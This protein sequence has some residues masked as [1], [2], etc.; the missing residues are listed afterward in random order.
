MQDT[1]DK[2]NINFAHLHVHTEFSLLDGSSKIKEIIDKTKELNMNSLAITDHGVMYG[3]ID[4]YKYALK[5]GIKPI[6]GCEVY[7]AE[8][9]RFDKVKSP[10]NNHHHLVLLAETNE[11]YNNLLKLVSLGHVEGF[12]Y[13]PR[14]DLEILRK[15]H[16]GLICLS[17]CLAG[18]VPRAILR[19]SYEAGKEVALTYKEIFGEDNFFLELQNH[20][21]QDQKLVNQNLIEMSEE[22]NIPLVCTNDVHYT[23]RSDEQSHDILLCIQTKKTVDD[24]NRMRYIGGQYYLKSPV[25]MLDLFGYVPEAL[26]NTQKIANRCNVEIDFNNYKLPVFP[27]PDELNINAFEYIKELCYDGLKDRYKD[28]NNNSELELKINERLDYEINIIKEMGFID[29]FLIVWDFIKY[30]RDN[31]IIVGP[32]R[33]SAAGSLVSYCLGITDIDPIEYNLIFERFLNPERVSMPDIDIDFCY[34]RRQE[35]ID[36]VNKKYGEDRVSQII[37]FGTLAARNAIRSVGRAISMP[38]DKVDKIAKMIPKELKITI[39]DALE[40]NP[41]LSKKYNQEEDVKYLIDMAMRLEGLSRHSSTHAAG[42]VIS[43]RPITDYIPVSRNDNII[44]TQFP[45]TTIEELGLLKMDFLGLR[46]LTVIK[47]AFDEINR[48]HNLNISYKDINYQ[49]SKIYELIASGNTEGIFQLES[50]GMKQMIKELQPHSIEDV[51][52][53]IS[54]YRPGPM[55]FI[56]NYIQGKN[57]KHNIKYDHKLLEPILKTTYGCIVYQEQVMQ[58]AQD[59]AGYNLGQSDLLRRA[60]GKKKTSEMEKERKN[61]IYG[62]EQIAG[63]LSNGISEGVA[64]K[65]FDQMQDFAKYAFNK[66]HAASYAVI[67]CQT[68]WIKAYYPLEFMS[69]L[70]TSVMD[71]IPKIAEYLVELRRIDIKILPPDINEGFS[72]F[73]VSGDKIRFNLAAIKNIGKKVVDIIVAE[74][75]KNGLYKSMRNFIERLDGDINLRA[76]ESLIKAGAFDSFGYNRAQN[77]ANCKNIQVSLSQ[78]KKTLV[79]G[80]LNLFDML[81]QN[82]SS[83][84][85]D[86]NKI[87]SQ[88]EDKFPP[89]QELPKSK[90]LAFE[91]ETLGIYIS[92]SPM[93]EYTEVTNKY[94]NAK[95]SD[96]LVNP[97]NNTCKVKDNQEIKIGG[98]IS[99]VEVRYVKKTGQQ[100]AYITIEDEFGL[101]ETIV[102]ASTY[103]KFKEL[104]YE[105]NIVLLK[106]KVQFE[107]EDVIKIISFE[108]KN[109]SDLLNAN[110][111]LWLK[112]PKDYPIAIEDFKDIILKHRGNIPVKVFDESKNIRVSM[113]EGFWIN[114]TQEALIELEL[115]IPKEC[116]KLV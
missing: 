36:Y 17:A 28:I 95:I 62:S 101:V 105:G 16:K 24:E 60:M 13:R 23:N 98:I 75:E 92:G 46:T 89:L 73:T 88:L 43:D 115:M 99:K 35:V 112:I 44:T 2:K 77:L 6:L 41:D 58:I 3:V 100:M 84:N 7:I 82:N 5:A 102:F 81:E 65:I 79:K 25:E 47:N 87:L 108:F 32:G 20:G 80:Q 39:K 45:M 107:D 68:A 15:Y 26:E 38:L 21:I 42:V 40:Q 85:D 70:L 9:S 113:K 67:S 52:A 61:F 91:K 49:D 55:Q 76:V 34:E 54:L 106:G 109:Y 86:N 59:L 104:L 8:N 29:Y 19:Q 66:S 97:D 31:D 57:D 51:I 93:D 30:A 78:M 22:L 111:T 116:I 56:P 90:L 71:N 4:F 69:A 1:L 27:I 64:S 53:G 72:R 12:Y 33:G 74:R 114:P 18:A 63:C 110:K 103:S 37:T 96:F 14:I 94:T 83:E 10:T 48:I 50:A 11:G